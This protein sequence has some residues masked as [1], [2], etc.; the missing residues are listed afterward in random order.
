MRLPRNLPLAGALLLLPLLFT[1]AC[2]ATADD[3]TPTP[4]Q[5][6]SVPR[7]ANALYPY[8]VFLVAA[9]GER[10]AQFGAY[11]WQTDSGLAIDVKSPGFPTANLEPLPVGPGETVRIEAR[12]GPAPN[13]LTV[14]VYARDGNTGPLSPDAP[15]TEAFKPQ[16]D[17]VTS[18]QLQLT[19][20]GRAYTWTVDL[21]PGTYFVLGNATWSN[22]VRPEKPRTVELTFAIEVAE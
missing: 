8:D 2:S 18:T 16:T 20:D 22:P 17:P 7:S 3:A 19:P 14:H 13:E 11:F 15:D 10:K 9:S 21:D 4:Q 1:I 6:P 12:D 5:Q